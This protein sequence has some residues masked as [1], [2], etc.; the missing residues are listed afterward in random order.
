M[1]QKKAAKR[2]YTPKVLQTELKPKSK[3]RFKKLTR[4]NDQGEHQGTNMK[5]HLSVYKPFMRIKKG[6]SRLGYYDGPQDLMGSSYGHE[7]GWYPIPMTHFN[8][9]EIKAQ[10][11]KPIGGVSTS[12]SRSSVE[13]F[14]DY[15]TY[16]AAMAF[17]WMVLSSSSHKVE[18][19]IVRFVMDLQFKAV[20]DKELHIG[21]GL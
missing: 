5:A 13:E 10:T 8:T 2:R 11:G 12:R 16:E 15:M 21:R 1:K 3:D 7:D 9:A 18:V 14:T 17:C 20:P 19:K 6:C 4:V